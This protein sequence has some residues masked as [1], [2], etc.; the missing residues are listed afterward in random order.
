MIRKHVWV[1][2]DWIE[3]DP[4]EERLNRARQPSNFPTV[5]RDTAP[6]VSPVTRKIIEGKAARREDLKRSNCREVDP[7]EYKP[8]YYTEK[9]A[10]I[11]GKDRET[12]PKVDLGDNFIRGKV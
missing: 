10:K 5:I 4:R 2:G 12:R 7:S 11:A 6:Y 1:D 9:Y 3:Y 8:V